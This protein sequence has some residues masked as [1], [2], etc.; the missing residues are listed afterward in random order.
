MYFISKYSL[1]DTWMMGKQQMNKEKKKRLQNRSF[2]VSIR[3]FESLAW[4]Y[5]IP[6]AIKTSSSLVTFCDSLLIS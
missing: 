5:L 6:R 1:S 2:A 3:L 4:H